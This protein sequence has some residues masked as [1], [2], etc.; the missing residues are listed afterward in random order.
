MSPG[1]FRADVIRPTLDRL[2]LWSESAEV[3]LLGTALT[4]SGLVWLRQKG[5][6]PALGV[7]QIEPA[8]HDDV[9]ANY[10]AYRP[11]LRDRVAALRASEPEP[12]AQLITNLAYATAIARLIYRRRPEPLPPAD[13]LA[14]LAA[15]WKAHYNTAGGAG[16]PDDFV[17][18]LRPHLPAAPP[19]V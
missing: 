9:W 11:G 17:N 13:D 7:Y 10:L 4:E 18:A 5:G 12:A 6:G 3:L 19:T 15:F 1:D 8:T 16:T 2:A 14:G